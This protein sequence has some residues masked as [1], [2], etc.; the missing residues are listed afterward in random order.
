MKLYTKKDIVQIFK[1]SRATLY[2][3]CREGDFPQP[4]N[5]KKG[6]RQYWRAEQIDKYIK[7]G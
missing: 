3:W 1:V 2:R 5:F 7:N 4:L 6:R